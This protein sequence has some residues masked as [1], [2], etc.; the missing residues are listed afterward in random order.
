MPNASSWNLASAASSSPMNERG[1]LL[2][3]ALILL[4]ACLVSATLILGLSTT[5]FNDR[6]L[7]SQVSEQMEADY[8]SSLRKIEPCRLCTQ[9]PTADLSSN[10]F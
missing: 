10:S 2:A 8:R 6:R 4:S 9:E 3:D 7:R 5:A 1:F